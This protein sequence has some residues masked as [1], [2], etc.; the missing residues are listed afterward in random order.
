MTVLQ[1]APVPDVIDVT[2]LGFRKD[3]TSI[4]RP[5]GEA[6]FCTSEHLDHEQHLV[7]VAAMPVRPRLTAAQAEA[8]VEGTGL[9]YSQREAVKGLLAADRFISCLVAP[10]GTGKTHAMAV[11]ARIWA[12]LT[13]GRVIGLSA[14]ENAARQL[15]GEGLT[16]AVNIAQFLGKV[17]DS[18]QTRGHM[19]VYPGDVLVIDEATQVSTED[20]LRIEAAARQGGATIIAA[21]DTEQLG[22]VDAGGIFRLIAAR[23]GAYRL[24][25]VRR[26]RQ[27]WERDASLKLR[28]GDITALAEYAARGR[29]YH[30]PQDRVRDDA[31]TLWVTDHLQGR[32]TLLLAASN[33][34]AAA[35]ARLARERLTELRKISG[36][37]EI[38]LADGNQAGTG[39]LVRARLNARIDADGQT[40]ANRDTIRIDGWQQGAFERLAIVSRKTGAGRWSRPFF[41]PAAYLE[42]NAELDYA[43]SI[44]VAQGRTVDTGHLVVSQGM[45]RDQLYVGSTRGRDKNTLHVVTGAPDPAQPGRAERE[46]HAD[47]AIRKARELRQAGDHEAADA[48]RLRMP[49]RPSEPADGALGGRARPG[50]A[51]QRPGGDRPG[52]HAGRAG[53]RDPHRASP[54]TDRG[55]LAP[56]RRAEDRR[57]GP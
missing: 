56:G 16:S 46:A 9:D 3:G 36:A 45:S 24:T 43:G 38:T 44:Y 53:L 20:M 49:D 57:D 2:R 10:A 6:L 11:F 23:H 55:V 14:S 26:F 54:G 35:L 8:A 15:A 28:E 32:D 40:L 4:Y 34:E 30:G 19:P 52:G 29:V 51:A 22:P 1:V 21:G 48:V 12:E 17:K 33:E 7:D 13:G 50:H 18:D 41:V 27:A 37:A 42:Q 47:A 31:V 39:D 5:P 25:E